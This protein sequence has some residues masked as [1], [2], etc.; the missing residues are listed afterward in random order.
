MFLFLSVSFCLKGQVQQC[1]CAEQKGVMMAFKKI[2]TAKRKSCKFKLMKALITVGIVIV[3]IL[4]II[5][6]IND[7]FG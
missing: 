7:L 3:K 6:R 1:R 4:R 5:A 2:K